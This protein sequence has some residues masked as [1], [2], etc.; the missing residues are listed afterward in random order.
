MV[1]HGTVS[2]IIYNTMQIEFHSR[3]NKI[4]IRKKSLSMG[5]LQ[6]DKALLGGLEPGF[7]E[8]LANGTGHKKI[9]KL[10]QHK[11]F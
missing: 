9:E 1:N 11:L 10:K 5:P 3:L 8:I 6:S 7:R 2:R 4:L